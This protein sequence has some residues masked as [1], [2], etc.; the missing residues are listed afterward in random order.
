[1]SCIVDKYYVLFENTSVNGIK[2]IYYYDFKKNKL[3]IYK[4]EI[5]LS[6]D[7]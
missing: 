3:K 2:N 6:K 1:M 7:T 5:I 4:P